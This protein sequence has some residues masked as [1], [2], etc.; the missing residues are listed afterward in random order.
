V[1]SGEET[2]G[3]NVVKLFRREFR[4]SLLDYPGFSAEPHPA[5]RRSRTCDLA[6][7][8]T[9]DFDYAKSPNP[10]ILHRKE[11]MLPPG[12]RDTR[13]F[14]AMTAAEEALGLYAEPATIGFRLAWERL[15]VAKGVTHKG[16]KVVPADAAGVTQPVTPVPLPHAVKRHRTAIGRA[17]LSRPVQCAMEQ[18]LLVR[19]KTFFDYGCGLGDDIHYLQ[20]LGFQAEGWDPA[21]CPQKPRRPADVVNLGFVL[22]VIEDPVERLAALREA[23]SLAD[24]ALVVAVIRPPADCGNRTWL[25]CGDGVM[26]GR[27]TFQKYFAQDELRQFLEDALGSTA[28]A[29]DLGIFVVF[30]DPVRCQE[31][32]AQRSRRCIDWDR[33]SPRL[34]PKRHAG[35]QEH[36]FAEHRALLEEFWRMVL[37][38]GR[39]P[40]PGEFGREADLRAALGSTRKALR[41]VLRHFGPEAFEEARRRRRED[42][43]V[44]LAVAN[45]RRPVPYRH[46]A[47]SLKADVKAFFGDYRKAL[48]EATESLYF[49]GDPDVIREECEAAT[50]GWQDEQALYVH[51]DL[52]GQLSVILRIYVGCAEMLYGSLGEVDLIK[53]HKRSGKVSFLIYDDFERK[54]LPELVMRV[55]VNLRNQQVDVFESVPDAEPEILYFKHRYVSPDHPKFRAWCR[56]S[57]Q[58]ER[59]GMDPGQFRAPGGAGARGL[60][61][62]VLQPPRS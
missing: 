26:T 3:F 55:K 52:V 56:L 17:Q 27:D 29:L 9:R 1:G 54:R 44:Y 62:P 12:H 13:R 41:F 5:L 53:I 59:A 4:I 60:S 7:G 14:A 11:A 31:F 32:M 39:P 48:A 38:L 45:L 30:R 46:L 23:Y 50:L 25:P 43:L 16:H 61:V 40:G 57:R 18:G 22:N 19:G 21:H 34:L 37:D 42:W 36:L 28:V 35:R 51:R 24:D 58:L 6:T 10:P 49:I 20:Q 8:Q 2:F 15:L 33:L 47:L